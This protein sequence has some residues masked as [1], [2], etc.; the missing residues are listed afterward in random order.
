[1]TLRA[2]LVI[3]QRERSQDIKKFYAE[4][5]SLGVT[6]PAELKARLDALQQKSAAGTA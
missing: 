3:L 2:A 1:M 4:A 5:S 6:V